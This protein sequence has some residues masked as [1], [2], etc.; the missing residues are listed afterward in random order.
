MLLSVMH[1]AG[2]RLIGGGRF[3]AGLQY[4]AEIEIYKQCKTQQKR[5]NRPLKIDACS[6][7]VIII[8]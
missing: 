8:L 7:N 6:A 5:S 3:K 1:C 2:T 4:D